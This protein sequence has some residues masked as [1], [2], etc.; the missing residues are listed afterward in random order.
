MSPFCLPELCSD[1]NPATQKAVTDLYRRV[2]LSNS[3]L[4][5][6]PPYEATDAHTKYLQSVDDFLEYA[7][8]FLKT[9]FPAENLVTVHIYTQDVLAEM[10][11]TLLGLFSEEKVQTTIVP[12]FLH[13]VMRSLRDLDDTHLEECILEALVPHIVD[14]AAKLETAS[15][16]VDTL[17]VYN[18]QDCA[19]TFKE[20]VIRVKHNPKP[21]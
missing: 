12:T 21:T 15:E 10:T 18:I 5:E 20:N 3:L 4:R 16:Y 1:I 8:K 13:D 2:R 19:R 6:A 14:L 17:W 9:S 11:H 7:L